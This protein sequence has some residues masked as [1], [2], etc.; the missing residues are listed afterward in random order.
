MAEQDGPVALGGHPVRPAEPDHASEL[1]R[2]VAG[3]A[4]CAAA[5]ESLIQAIDIQ[6]RMLDGNDVISN[7]LR[8]A[9]GTIK[10]ML[11]ACLTSQ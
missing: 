7:G 5:V 10:G 11:R 2:R 3:K 9:F 1:D 6:D 8:S 4:A